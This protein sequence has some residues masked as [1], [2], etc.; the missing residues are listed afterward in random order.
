MGGNTPSILLGPNEGRDSVSTIG[1]R[2]T[3]ACS[4]VRGNPG[5]RCGS[6]RRTEP[7]HPLSPKLT[8]R[9]FPEA[10]IAVEEPVETLWIRRAQLFWSLVLARPARVIWPVLCSMAPEEDALTTV[11]SCCGGLLYKRFSRGSSIMKSGEEGDPVVRERKEV[12]CVG[13]QPDPS[14]L[15]YLIMPE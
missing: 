5:S 12:G 8:P 4:R 15:K 11:S 10:S 1:A 13:S 9:R 3:C 2:P 6:S 7:V 14:R